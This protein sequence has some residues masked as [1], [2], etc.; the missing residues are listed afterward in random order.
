MHNMITSQGKHVSDA[1]FKTIMVENLPHSWN[2]FIS[3]LLTQTTT[4]SMTVTQLK[5]TLSKEYQRLIRQ[6]QSD[7]TAYT[8]SSS[9][10]TKKGKAVCSICEH[11][12]HVTKDCQ[13]FGKDA[14]KCDICGKVGHKTEKCWRNPTNQG[15]GCTNKERGKKGK[16]NPA[17]SSSKGKEKACANVT[18]Q[19]SS[20]DGELKKSFTAFVN[21]SDKG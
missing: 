17:L 7:A 12:N 8:T 2:P 21:I 16:K 14:P 20:S 4:K 6:S 11:C 5:S 3:S 10:H 15:K 1:D 13:W 9:S 19:E 18:E